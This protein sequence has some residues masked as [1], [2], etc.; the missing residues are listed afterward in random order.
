MTKV[1][2]LCN[3]LIKSNLSIF[4]IKA[5]K[6]IDPLA[7]FVPNWHIDYLCDILNAVEKKQINKLII[8]LPPR[9]LKSVIVNV[10][11]PAW[12]L[13][14][15]PSEKI[16]STSYSSQ[17]ALKHSTDTRLL[18]ESDWYTELFPES[19]ILKGANRQSKFCTIKNGYRL[20]TST[21][22]SLTGEGGN[23]LIMD[24]PQNPIKIENKKYRQSTIDWF[25]NVFM[26]RLNDK[27]NGCMIL[28]MQRLHKEDL[29]QFLLDT[30]DWFHVNIPLIADNDYKVIFNNI[31]YSDRQKGDVLNEKIYT[32]SV[33][34]DLKKNAGDIIFQTQYQQN[35]QSEKN[36]LI[37][38]EHLLS[39]NE[40]LSFDNISIS[41]DCASGVNTSH[42]FS[43]IGIFGIIGN[44]IYLIEMI[45]LKV[46]YPE[47]K[48]E[49][50]SIIN[51]Y[52]ISNIIIENASNGISL[53]QDLKNS[54]SI[55]VIGRSPRK[56]K[57]E[58]VQKMIIFLQNKRFFISDN[59]F[60]RR[61]FIDEIKLFPFCKNDDQVDCISQFI[62]WYMEININQKSPKILFF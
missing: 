49:I 18:M 15:E 39:Y 4:T 38:D 1:K 37:Q 12:I 55:N 30:N 9:S 13:A 16:I 34:N 17:I 27:Q 44:K 47:L 60:K 33:I 21:N 57:E 36:R 43:A 3:Q 50:L 14:K 10:A 6:T 48:N 26:S 58:R 42:D 59:L 61:D 2:K 24:D 40:Q 20:C 41:V 46:E 28:V 31:E 51:L 45:R 29:T 56:S 32:K 52:K 53:I 35:P 22:G 25:S 23:I 54:L 7:K 11:F 8:N 62:D 5:L 19:K